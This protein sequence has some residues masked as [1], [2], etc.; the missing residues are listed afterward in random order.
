MPRK[1]LS[2]KL[3]SHNFKFS[4]KTYPNLK[5]NC[6]RLNKNF[7]LVK[8]SMNNWGKSNSNFKIKSKISNTNCNKSKKSN[9]KINKEINNS[10]K[11]SNLKI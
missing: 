7:L 6:Y 8:K 5:M 11:Y 4:K 9:L 10:I 2:F 1:Q 3:K